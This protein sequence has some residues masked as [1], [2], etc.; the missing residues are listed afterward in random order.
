M[1]AAVSGLPL[2]RLAKKEVLPEDALVYRQENLVFVVEGEYMK[3]VL[4]AKK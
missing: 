4:P 2:L 1:N 3:V